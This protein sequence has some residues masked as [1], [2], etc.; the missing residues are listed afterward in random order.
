MATI[1]R[2]GPWVTNA[3]SSP[4]IRVDPALS[5]VPIAVKYAVIGILA[6]CLRQGFRFS[7]GSGGLHEGV[8]PAMTRA[9]QE[10]IGM[11]YATAGAGIES[12]IHV[13]HAPPNQPFH[14]AVLA[15]AP[16]VE[17]DDPRV[18]TQLSRLKH[19][20]AMCQMKVEIDAKPQQAT[21]AIVDSGRVLKITAQYITT[22]LTGL[23]IAELH[24]LG[25]LS[26]HTESYARTPVPSGEGQ[27]DVFEFIPYDPVE[28]LDDFLDGQSAD[29][30]EEPEP[31]VDPQPD[32]SPQ[33][34][35]E[36][37]ADG[38]P[39]ALIWPPVQPQAPAPA[40]SPAVTVAS[41]V[42][43]PEPQSTPASA[44]SDTDQPVG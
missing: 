10:Y 35:V 43:D 39:P 21:V 11:C 37:P 24:M 20:V 4:V 27:A 32:S 9:I 19:V 16:G 18:H 15:L 12:M 5:R 8:L 40:V 2:E 30:T 38:A 6:D 13:I 44:T 33:S 34:G 26:I 25:R 3:T 22:S 31:A 41:P 1:W 29:D 36:V 42:V 14:S 23:V 17:L 7:Y 28:N